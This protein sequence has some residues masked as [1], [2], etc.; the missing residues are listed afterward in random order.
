MIIQITHIFITSVG[1]TLTQLLEVQ[2][3]HNLVDLTEVK[4]E[5]ELIES[6]NHFF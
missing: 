3:L 5:L 6:A 2:I 1:K 4:S